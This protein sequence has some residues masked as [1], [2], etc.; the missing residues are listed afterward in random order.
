M[1]TILLIGLIMFI[2]IINVFILSLQNYS[3]TRLSQRA[4]IG[5]ENFVRLFVKDSMFKSSIFITLKWVFFEVL[6]Q[7]FFGLI[8]SLLLNESFRCRSLV[9]AVVFIPW[10]VSGVLTTMLWILMYNEHI[11]I[12][13]ALFIKF[14]L[15]NRP[16][17][18]LA[19]TKTVFASVIAAEVWRGIPFFAITLLAAL[20]TIPRDIYESCDVDGFSAWQKFL[21]ITLP[22]LKDSIILTTLLRS[23][24]EFNSIDMIFTMT[25]GGPMNLTTTVSIYLMQTAILKTDYGY[26]SAIGASCFFFLLLFSIIYLGWSRYSKE[27]FNG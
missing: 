17:A 10:A 5:F 8:I 27:N 26:G 25:S 7:L 22:F 24:W 16:I 6:L 1:P 18:W 9:R 20:Q 23:I 14:G 21:Y 15:I 2:P 13:N 11:G 12:I 4:F 3:F 19:N